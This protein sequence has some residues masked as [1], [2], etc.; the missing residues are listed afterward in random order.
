MRILGILLIVLGL[1]AYAFGER[2]IT[3]RREVA[4]FGVFNATVTEHE[5]LPAARYAG[6][7][8]LAGG[9]LVVG[10]GLR[11]RSA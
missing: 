1:A 9:A 4:N 11:R 6:V 2:G 8:L 5:P 3:R 7:G 10:L